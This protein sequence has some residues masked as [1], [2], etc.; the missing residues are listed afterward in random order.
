MSHPLYYPVPA[1]YYPLSP[2]TTTLLHNALLGVMIGSTAATATQ[3]RKTPEARA[4][5][6]GSIIKAGVATGLATAVVTAIG[7]NISPNHSNLATV[8]TMFV[9]GTA[10]IYTLNQDN[11]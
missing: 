7:Q 5:P 10:L 4:N 2:Q 6:I 1:N 8:A 3:L 9:A 11:S